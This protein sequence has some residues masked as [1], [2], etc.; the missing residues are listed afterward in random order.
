MQTNTT[1]PLRW[2]RLPKS[3]LSLSRRN[4]IALFDP[5]PDPF[6]N[7]QCFLPAERLLETIAAARERTGKRITLTLAMVKLLATA[8]DL[9]PRF[10]RLVLGGDV[11][12]LQNLSFTLPVLIPGTSN[13]LANLILRD[14]HTRSLEALH[15]E[16]Q[17]GREAGHTVSLRARERTSWLATWIIRSRLYRAIGEKRT[18]QFLHARGLAS[19]LVLTNASDRGLGRM[20]VTKSGIHFLRFFTRFY[21]H[22]A[23]DRAVVEDGA[24][25]ARKV[26]PLTIAFDHRVI[27]GAHLNGFLETLEEL[28]AGG[29]A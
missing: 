7:V 23:Q 5:S 24:V 27:D 2:R 4:L 20:T 22:G 12:Q 29:L 18:Y 28:A 21:L 6:I 3:E 9:H 15:D 10:N 11:Y 16:L 14:P 19:N 25:V 1:T 8:I 13:E 26:I 17:R